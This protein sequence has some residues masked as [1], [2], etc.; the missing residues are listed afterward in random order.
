MLDL[1]QDQWFVNLKIHEGMRAINFTGDQTMATKTRE[2]HT[3]FVRNDNA[4]WII[5]SF[6]FA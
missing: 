3:E 2:K 1:I 4:K 5:C 6:L